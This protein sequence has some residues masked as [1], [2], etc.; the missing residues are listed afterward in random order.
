M[1]QYG[2]FCQIRDI[3]IVTI[4]VDFSDFLIALYGSNYLVWTA[5]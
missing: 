3:M 2:S 5:H 4:Y 1:C